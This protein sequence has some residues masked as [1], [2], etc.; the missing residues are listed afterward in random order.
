MENNN[1][2]VSIIMPTLNSERTIRMSLESIRKQHFDQDLIE[3]LVLDGGSSD[4]TVEIAKEFGCVVMKNEKKLPE[5]AKH[6]GILSAKGRYV[7]FFDSDEV[8]TNMDAIR[9]RVDIF[10]EEKAKI[11]FTGGYIKPK[12]AHYINDY[13]NNFSDPFSYF[14]YGTSSGF[15]YYLKSMLAAY[16]HHA[17]R[18]KYAVLFL[19][20]NSRLPLSD[21]C[22]GNA[23]DANYAKEL[24]G[25]K[26]NDV[27]MLTQIIYIILK[28]D[29]KIFMLKDDFIVHHS[30][31]SLRKY[32]NKIK[33]RVV[34]NMF[35]GDEIAGFTKRESH[36]SPQIRFKK[37]LFMPYS[38][39][40]VFP[41]I[42]GVY[43]AIRRKS[44]ACLL[45]PIL[46]F[47]TGLIISYYYVL[48]I[49]G[50]K[51]SLMVYGK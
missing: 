15:Q 10:Q 32:L 21:L 42:Y 37:Y 27:R 29:R 18:E 46:T 23:I 47:Y 33:W 31:D 5:Y 49:M 36:D 35:H 50:A 43:S 13:I 40:I 2:L 17:I 1:V 16:G 22:A 4:K 30:S 25:E 41:L 7:I 39:T 24:L 34:S 8:F 38:L 12:G 6:I 9:N 28:K 48:K 3:I 44:P 26:I 11:I 20:E 45:H 19:D 14:M 51:P